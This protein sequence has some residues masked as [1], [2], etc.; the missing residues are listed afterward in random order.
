MFMLTLPGMEIRDDVEMLK[1]L[2]HI[3]TS[4][5]SL[6][7]NS[8]VVQSTF[9]IICVLVYISRFAKEILLLLTE[10]HAGR[11]GGHISTTTLLQGCC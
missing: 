4:D 5:F 2:S 10:P 11:H 1:F 9:D 6:L 7:K 8:S 3:H